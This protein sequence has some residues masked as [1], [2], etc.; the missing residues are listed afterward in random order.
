M[1]AGKTF[2]LS[3]GEIEKCPPLFRWA[4]GK[5]R[6][7][8]QILPLLPPKYN[9]YYEPFCGGAA[10]FFELRPASATLCDKNEELIN[11]YQQVKE[12]PEEVI[13]AFQKLKRNETTYYEVR[14]RVPQNP[15]ARAARLIYLMAL[16]FN[17]IY[18][19]N[20]KGKFN[21]P[22][23]SKTAKAYDI[24]RI[25]KVSKALVGVELVNGDFETAVTKAGDGDL[26]YFDPPYVVDYLRYNAA[27]LSYNFRFIADFVGS[28]PFFS[29][30]RI[31]WLNTDKYQWH[32]RD[33]ATVANDVVKLPF[34]ITR[35]G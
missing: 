15:I 12:R 17:G 30:N 16:S 4:G 29:T 26:V 2:S 20:S 23:G 33:A 24:E 8:S 5:R 22:C 1:E 18:R 32:G 3:A 9:H 35:T 14:E 13:A 27:L 11:C 34:V 25:R 6:L 28:F 10:L 31:L 19:V 21:V 7:L